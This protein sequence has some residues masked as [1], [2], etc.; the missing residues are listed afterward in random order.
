MFAFTFAGRLRY[1]ERNLAAPVVR[2]S[3]RYRFSPEIGSSVV[4]AYA[5]PDLRAELYATMFY[6]LVLPDVGRM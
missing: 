6:P 4:P 3:D 5:G 2:F 1:D